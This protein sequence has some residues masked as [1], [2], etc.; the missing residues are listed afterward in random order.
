LCPTALLPLG[1]GWEAVFL[2]GPDVPVFVQNGAADLGIVGSDVLEEEAPDVYDLRAL[3]FGTCRLSLAGP[4]GEDPP[5][6]WPLRVATKEM[7]WW[8]GSRV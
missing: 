4:G 6:E 5:R 3:G 7:R 8:E 2:K 1:S